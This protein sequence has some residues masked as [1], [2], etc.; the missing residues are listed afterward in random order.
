[1]KFKN[2]CEHPVVY[3][4]R[5]RGSKVRLKCESC[6]HLGKWTKVEVVTEPPAAPVAVQDSK[7]DH[8]GM[9]VAELRALAKGAGITGYS[10]MKKSDLVAALATAEQSGELVGT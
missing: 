4:A 1:M 3:V 8:E 7:P 5:Q 2:E 6:G 9:T 10:K